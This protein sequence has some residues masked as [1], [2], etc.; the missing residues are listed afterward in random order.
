MSYITWA[1]LNTTDDYYLQCKLD[2]TGV[3]MVTLHTWTRLG[4]AAK[5]SSHTSC[6]AWDYSEQKQCHLFTDIDTCRE[7]LIQVWVGK[8]LHLYFNDCLYM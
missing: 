4:C 5:C 8:F 1:D 3:P 7:G 2:L 6:R